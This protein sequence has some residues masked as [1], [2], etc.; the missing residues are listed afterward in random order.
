MIDCAGIWRSGSS[1]DCHPT[2]KHLSGFHEA[3]ID[4]AQKESMIIGEN[5]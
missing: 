5:K 3:G 1:A 4:D 2:G